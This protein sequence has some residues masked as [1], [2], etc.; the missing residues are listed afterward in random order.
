MISPLGGRLRAARHSR[1]VGRAAEKE[2]FETAL[3][4]SE[5]PFFVLYL[6][7]PGGVG[8]TTLLQ[9]YALLCEREKIPFLYLDVR[10]IDPAPGA[11]LDALYGGIGLAENETFATH[12]AHTSRFVILIDTY[13]TLAPLDDWLRE[14]FL[15]ELPENTLVVLAGRYPL[16]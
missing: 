5:L 2:L 8:K 3:S 7:G 14:M 10:N 12:I 16:S 13:E 15:P 6:Y 1:F 9:E 4:A 11:F